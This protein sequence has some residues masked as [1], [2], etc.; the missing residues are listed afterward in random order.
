MPSFVPCLRAVFGILFENESQSD[1][2]GVRIAQHNNA[3]RQ[4]LV[5]KGID[6]DR[7]LGRRT[8]NR[9]P[10]EQFAINGHQFRIRPIFRNP[11]MICW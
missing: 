4:L 7:W 11:G 3:L 8:E 10:E 6:V 9:M 1:E 5:Q 2:E